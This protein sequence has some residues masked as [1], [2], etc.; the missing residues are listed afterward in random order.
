[1]EEDEEWIDSV[2]YSDVVHFH[3]GGQSCSEALSVHCLNLRRA[4]IEHVI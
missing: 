3:P 4:H 2:R 1:M